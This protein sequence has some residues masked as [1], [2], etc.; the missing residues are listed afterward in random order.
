M[1][2]G[3]LV[4]PSCFTTFL[5]AL[6]MGHI[7]MSRARSEG[8]NA[9]RAKLGLIF[10]YG[11]LVMLP[12]IAVIAGLVAPLVIRQRQKADQTEIVSHCREIGQAL[13]EYDAEHGAFPPDL[14]QL[15]TAGFTTNL[16]EL[17]GM[18]ARNGGEWLYF[19]KRENVDSSF[20]I[21]ISPPI[22]KSRIALRLDHSCTAMNEAATVE[23]VGKN[24][25]VR[26]PAPRRGGN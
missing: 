23:V 17:L 19:P 14:K 8:G 24:A 2:C 3:I 26:I 15:E 9:G 5:P 16:N 25:P 21:L 13:F 12:V 18:N 20:P 11:S 10:G 22:G 4:L 6:I 1:I 7:A